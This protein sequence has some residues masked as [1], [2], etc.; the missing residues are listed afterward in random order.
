MTNSRR[1][2]TT[3]REGTCNA[4]P[5]TN[6]EI[7]RSRRASPSFRLANYRPTGLSLYDGNLLIEALEPIMSLDAAMTAMATRTKIS[8]EDLAATSIHRR[9]CVTALK[10]HI[11]PTPIY[12]DFFCAFGELLRVGYIGRDPL[13]PSAIAAYYAEDEDFDDDRQNDLIG[14]YAGNGAADESEAQSAGNSND[15][16]M[17]RRQ[18]M[19]TSGALGIIGTSGMGKTTLALAVA[20]CY[21]QVW[22]HRNYK[23]R[24][25]NFTQVVWLYMQCPHDGSLVEF[26]DSFFEALDE[27]LGTAYADRYAQG[28]ANSKLR[29]MR[30]LVKTYFIGALIVDELQNLSHAKAGGRKSMLAFFNRLVSHVG[31]PIV[32]VGTYAA[33]ALFEEAL[34]AARRATGDGGVFNLPCAKPDDA[35]WA[36]IKEALWDLQWTDK[37]AELTDSVSTLLDVLSQGVTAIL[38]LLLS[39]AQKE[40]LKLSMPMVDADLLMAVHDKYFGL[41]KPALAALKSGKPN[42]LQLFEDLMPRMDV[43]TKHIEQLEGSAADPTSIASLKWL[44]ANRTPARADRATSRSKTPVPALRLPAFNFDAAAIKAMAGE[45]LIIGSLEDT[46]RIGSLAKAGLLDTNPPELTE[47][48]QA[49]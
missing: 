43:I 14:G 21:R 23:G 12:F 29:K 34:S 31:V 9:H 5:D 44:Q 28:T 41:L 33:T 36:L 48:A 45:L 15:S 20:R 32:Y 38:Y 46:D 30:R 2:R 16:S 25:I 19:T 40:A 6:R 27:V 37:F 13:D 49:P 4:S 1:S 39:L 3:K 22:I 42:A 10:F 26:C 47:A 24:K 7:T 35:A 8:D 17:L 11:E 18:T